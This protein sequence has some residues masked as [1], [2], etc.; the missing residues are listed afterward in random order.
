MKLLAI[1]VQWFHDMKV[2]TQYTNWLNS[3][4]V[5][6]TLKIRSCDVMHMRLE[7]KLEF[8]KKGNAFLYTEESVLK[9]IK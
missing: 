1:Y 8:M 4:E 6:K 9:N 5:V 3:K 7:G 2:K